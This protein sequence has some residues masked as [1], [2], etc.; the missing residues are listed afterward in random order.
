MNDFVLKEIG[1]YN[2]HVEYLYWRVALLA[3]KYQ[4]NIFNFKTRTFLFA[5]GLLH[6][7]GRGSCN[8]FVA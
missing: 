8:T 4:S 6:C 5:A 1:F 3:P 2:L 7:Q